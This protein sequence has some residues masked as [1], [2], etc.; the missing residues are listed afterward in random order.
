MKIYEVIINPLQLNQYNLAT[1]DV[2]RALRE[3]N[4]NVGADVLE[5]APQSFIV[6]GIGLVETVQ[7]IKQIRRRYSYSYF[8]CRG[9]KG[10]R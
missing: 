5:I 6:R 7:D 3:N 9:G 8:K 2:F 1:D 10:V 4:S